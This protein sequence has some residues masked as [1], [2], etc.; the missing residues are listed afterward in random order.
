MSAV[1]Q[2]WLRVATL[3]ELER[4]GVRV[5]KGAD[6]PIAVYAHEGKV[7]AVDNRC[8]HLGF[9]LHK[10]TVQDGILTCPLRPLQ[11]LHF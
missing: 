4:Q 9:P 3:D 2:E 7:Y 5:V 8:P 11:R 10:G 6:R 1:G